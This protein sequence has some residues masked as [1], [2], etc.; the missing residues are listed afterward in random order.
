M[1]Y[2]IEQKNCPESTLNSRKPEKG[3]GYASF[4]VLCSDYSTYHN[5]AA[6]GHNHYN[7]KSSRACFNSPLLSPK[8]VCEIDKLLSLV[9]GSEV[10]GKL[11][12]M[13]RDYNS[14]LPASVL[15]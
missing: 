5:V 13:Y 9:Q 14:S 12:Q 4:Y 3:F 1:L 10:F 2:G 11:S 6:E 8:K 7:A 15:I